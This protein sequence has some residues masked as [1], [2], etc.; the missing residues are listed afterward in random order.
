MKKLMTLVLAARFMP[1]LRRSPSAVEITA[2]VQ[3]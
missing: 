3:L 2:N 1:G